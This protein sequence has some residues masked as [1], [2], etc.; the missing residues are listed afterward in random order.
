MQA[1]SHMTGTMCGLPKKPRQGG[2]PDIA[3]GEGKNKCEKCYSV[4][5]LGWDCIGTGRFAGCEFCSIGV[6]GSS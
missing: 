4:S 5:I 2:P 1:P 6:N 3:R